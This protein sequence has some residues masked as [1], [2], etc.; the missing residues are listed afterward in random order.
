MGIGDNKRKYA[1][2]L[3]YASLE[4]ALTQVISEIYKYKENF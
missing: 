1:E 3:K 2:P 4:V